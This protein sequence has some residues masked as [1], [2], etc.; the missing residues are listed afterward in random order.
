M[1][2][3]PEPKEKL[4]EYSTWKTSDFRNEDYGDHRHKIYFPATSE[5]NGF[6][7][8]PNIDVEQLG[9]EEGWQFG[10]YDPGWQWSRWR[11]HGILIADTF[12]VVWLD[13]EHKL[14]G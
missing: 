10:I 14:F 7:D 2:G 13:P 5:P 3:I 12:F 1:A 8:V 11:V 6:Q 9:S 4:Q